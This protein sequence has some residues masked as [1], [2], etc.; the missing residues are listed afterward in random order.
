M[1]APGALEFAGGLS[2]AWAGLVLGAAALGAAAAGAW[3]AGRGRPAGFRLL[4]GALYAAAA[5]ALAAALLG[6]ESVLVSNAPAPLRVAVLVDRSA[7]MA[8][9]DLPGGRA[10]WELAGRFLADGS[11][12]RA[13]L[14]RSARARLLAFDSEFR[15]LAPDDLRTP[16]AGTATDPAGALGAALD[17]P[18]PGRLGLVILV[19]DGRSTAGAPLALAAGELAERRVPV[20]TVG[21]AAPAAAAAGRLVI[22]GFDPPETAALG[23]PIDAEATIEAANLAERKISVRLLLD[24]R[25][26]GAQDLGPASAGDRLPVRFA[27]AARPEGVR[28]LELVASSGAVSTRAVR[29][30]VVLE[31][32]LRAFYAEGRLGWGW[33]EIRG[34]LAAVPDAELETWAGFLQP[35]GVA[36]AAD[37]GLAG[38]VDRLSLVVLGDVEAGQLGPRALAA[39]ARA[40]REDGCGLLFMA[41]PERAAGYRGTPLEPLLPLTLDG[42]RNS[43]RKA[44]RVELVGEAGGAGPLRLDPDG[45]ANHR[46]WS[47]LPETRSDCLPGR[48]RPGAEVWLSAGGEPV[49]A[50]WKAGAGRAA[51]MNWPDHWRWARA[52]PDGAEAHRRFFARLA[53]WLAGR[54]DSG[55]GR[56]A[57]AMSKYRLAP[58]EEVT[59]LARLL[60][61]PEPKL[62][63]A[64]SAAAAREGEA[65]AVSLPLAVAGPGLWRAG[66]RAG[67]AG[68]YRVEV[69]AR[70]GG[71][72]WTRAEIFYSVEGA[73]LEDENPAPDLAGLAA[74]A[75]ATGGRHFSA[76]EADPA[77]LAA[78]VRQSLPPPERRE[79]RV[80]AALWDRGWLM[81]PALGALSAAWILLRRPSAAGAE[82]PSDNCRYG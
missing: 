58:G 50:V 1:S 55:S 42:A 35:A 10:R 60:K 24:G 30:L 76:E 6:P 33:R 11:P 22:A 77:G 32:P 43:E 12:L 75:R 69:V 62:T 5:L 61:E 20:W 49:L 2:P 66:V 7:S 29:H 14:A 9:R 27:F 70:A 56:L 4:V 51:T 40:V 64:M 8:R 28:R 38:K 59:L 36:P 15:P 25:E 57:L 13:E 53:V 21:A 34:A 47:S 37:A 46:L 39:L 31:R 71:A 23:Q 65:Q 82:P 26:I 45:A 73:R 74:V 68:Q 80:R 79:R 18:G 78:L 72:E 44:G 48:P 54:Q 17:S 41:A 63:V 16:P 19:S 81:L 52:S 67:A 3:L